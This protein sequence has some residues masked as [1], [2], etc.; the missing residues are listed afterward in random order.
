MNELSG[1]GS[2]NLLLVADGLGKHYGRVVALDGASLTIRR[3]EVHAIVG[4]NG[5]GKSTLIKILSGVIEPDSGSLSVQGKEHL[6]SS[7][8]EARRAGIETVFQDLALVPELD[9][10]LNFFL[11]RELVRAGLLGKF[12][13]LRRHEMH[14]EALAALTRLGVEV[15]STSQPVVKLSG[16]QRQSVAIARAV[17]GGAELVIM[18][19]PTAAL[20]VAQ[21]AM[22]MELVKRI[23]EDGK[24]VLLISHTLPEVLEVAD[25]IT[26]LRRGKTVVTLSA[27]STSVE[28]IIAHMT[29]A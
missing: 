25:R 12:G 6:F 7:P 14:T 23:R 10:A 15:K 16:G 22:V 20:G 1:R 8:R 4:D 27:Q 5:A 24:S 21:S 17:Q 9:V 2:D 18:D 19:E 11:G 26:V 13:L 29:G 3:G 28:T